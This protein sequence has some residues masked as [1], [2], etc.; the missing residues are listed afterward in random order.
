MEQTGVEPWT[1]SSRACALNHHVFYSHWVFCFMVKDN[2]P[3]SSFLAWEFYY[4]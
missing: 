4:I 2:L 3:S 1:Y